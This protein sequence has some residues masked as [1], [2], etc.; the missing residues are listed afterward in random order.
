[1]PAACRESCTALP[2]N[3]WV[4]LKFSFK[5]FG[6]QIPPETQEFARE[7]AKIVLCNIVLCHL[8][9][10]P[11]L[12]S[13]TMACSCVS[14]MSLAVTL[15]HQQSFS[16]Q[17]LGVSTPWLWLAL[18]SCN[19]LSLLMQPSQ[20]L[21]SLLAN[22]ACQCFD[23]LFACSLYLPFNCGMCSLDFHPTQ[24]TSINGLS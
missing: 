19:G 2:I 16:L 13:H 10:P 21:V 20:A 17:F 22:T 3:I 12:I 18:R 9:R 6:I 14:N 8:R 7:I 15:C 1:M 23:D 24:Q 4:S 11:W 5:T